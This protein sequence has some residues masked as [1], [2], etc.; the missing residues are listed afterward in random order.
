MFRSKWIILAAAVLVGFGALVILTTGDP[1]PGAITNAERSELQ[2]AAAPPA[3]VLPVM[4][5]FY[6]DWCPSCQEM[7]PVVDGLAEEYRG[8]VEIRQLDVESDSAAA[9]LASGF[10]VQYVPTFV[11]VNADGT[12]SDTIVGEVSEA[13]LRSALDAL[14]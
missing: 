5:E 9:A 14:K 12:T 1:A 3:S 2:S 6:T 8:I 7:A 10:R 11:F 4:Y 13:K